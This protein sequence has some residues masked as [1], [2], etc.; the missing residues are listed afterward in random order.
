M[1]ECAWRAGENENTGEMLEKQGWRLMGGKRRSARMEEDKKGW[2]G[3][4][5]G[6]EEANQNNK[7]FQQLFFS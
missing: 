5:E 6:G 4:Q 7:L 2:N 1:R 3:G